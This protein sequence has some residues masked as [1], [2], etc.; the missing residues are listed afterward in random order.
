MGIPYDNCQRFRDRDLGAWTEIKPFT[1]WVITQ[2][3]GRGAIRMEGDGSAELQLLSG[4]G[5]EITVHIDP[6]K[7]PLHRVDLAVLIA[8][9]F[10]E[11]IMGQIHRLRM[12]HAG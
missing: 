6:A 10:L 1:D 8:V 2:L 4:S 12:R 7:R 11:M 5:L 3:H 9:Q